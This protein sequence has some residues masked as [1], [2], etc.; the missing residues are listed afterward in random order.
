MHLFSSE[1]LAVPQQTAS[2]AVP[3][4]TAA[5]TLIYFALPGLA[6]NDWG[7]WKS[8]ARYSAKYA[9]LKP[10]PRSGRHHDRALYC[11]QV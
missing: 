6:G 3:E 2:F 4:G 10:F 1:Q 8:L 9:G 7:S 11:R 5:E